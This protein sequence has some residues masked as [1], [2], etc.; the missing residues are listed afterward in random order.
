MADSLLKEVDDALRAD[1]AAGLWQHY[2]GAII[3]VIVLLIL[4]AAGNSAW[5][6]YYEARGGEWLLKLTQYEAMLDSG[7]VSEAAKGFGEV[8]ASASGDVRTLALVWQSRALVAAGNKDEAVKLLKTAAS[9]SPSL[10]TD[11][12]CL[13]LAGLDANEASCLSASTDSP[14][15]L[16]RAQWA[17]AEAWGKGERDAAITAL[18]KLIADETVSQEARARLMQWRAT[19]KAQKQ[20]QASN[21]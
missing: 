10:W 15:K 5:Q 13:R 11:I 14:L 12:A 1:R 2:R 3:G 7:K 16:E 6:H 9:G 18:D 8:A 4:A 19:I 20:K 21:G 17:A